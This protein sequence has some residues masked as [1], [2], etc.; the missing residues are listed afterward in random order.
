MIELNQYDREWLMLDGMTHEDIAHL[1]GYIAKYREK[2]PKC[3]DCTAQAAAYKKLKL[4][5]RVA[6]FRA[7]KQK[8]AADKLAQA[9]I[10]GFG[11]N[12]QDG[13]WAPFN[14]K[15]YHDRAKMIADARALGLEE[16]GG[17]SDVQYM[18]DRARKV[19]KEAKTKQRASIRDSLVQTLRTS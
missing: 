2:F 14:G 8:I 15:V 17:A 1:E 6:A 3:G 7:K 13:V 18:Q 11:S 4:D 12:Y 9:K 10:N 16:T 5:K 19:K